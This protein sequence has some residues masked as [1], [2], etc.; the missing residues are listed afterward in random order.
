MNEWK[1]T[2]SPLPLWSYFICYQEL[3]DQVGSTVSS[4]LNL[5][6]ELVRAGVPLAMAAIE[7]APALIN[8]TRTAIETLHSQENRERV[9]QI[10]G[11]GSRVAA[12]AGS[13]ASQAPLLLS[14][15]TRLAGSIIHAANETAP[16]VVSV[17]AWRD[18]QEKYHDFSMFSE[19]P[20]IH[21]SDSAHSRICERLR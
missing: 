6:G 7:Q 19:H 14:Q 1:K 15:G 10:A 21:R 8:T 11:V 9:S 4:G 18:D 13:V 17:G 16:L 12:S 3:R 5:T 20:G 2:N